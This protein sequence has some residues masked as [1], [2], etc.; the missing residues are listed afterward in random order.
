MKEAKVKAKVSMWLIDK[1]YKID[2]F[3]QF[4]KIVGGSFKVKVFLDIHNFE[5]RICDGIFVIAKNTIQYRNLGTF[6]T[7]PEE[8]IESEI[9]QLAIGALVDSL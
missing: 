3:N 1:G 5:I 4:Y 8:S 2:V 7:T 6:F 9:R